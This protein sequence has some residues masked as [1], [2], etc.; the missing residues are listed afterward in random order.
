MKVLLFLAITFSATITSAKVEMKS[1]YFDKYASTPTGL[2]K[3]KLEELKSQVEENNFQVIEINSF[4]SIEGGFEKN[5]ALSQKRID[6]VLDLLE[7]ESSAITINTFGNERVAINFKP[8]SWNR[9]DVYYNIPDVIEPNPLVIKGEADVKLIEHVDIK[10]PAELKIESTSD[11]IEE[12]QVP[13]LSEIVEDI[14][15]IM[16]IKFEGG[17]NE[18]MDEDKDF[19][20]HLYRTLAKHPTLKAHIRGHVCCGNNKR[21]S[22]Q[23]AKIVYEYLISKGIE[24]NRL[25]FKGYSNS[26]PIVYPERTKED[27][28]KNRRVDVIFNK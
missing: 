25:S 7:L 22:K 26:Q 27:R 5:K 24:K 21:I 19:L 12:R 1:I 28:R 15:I 10:E 3:G 20:D 16:P 2:S 4:S 8:E 18:I 11:N 14:P 23:R 6:F 13:K 9:V 17:T